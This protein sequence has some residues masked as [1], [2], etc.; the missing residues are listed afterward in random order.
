MLHS[1]P[2]RLSLPYTNCSALTAISLLLLGRFAK[3]GAKTKN[4]QYNCIYIRKDKFK[5]SGD[6]LPG[7]FLGKRYYVKN[8]NCFLYI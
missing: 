6:Y 2:L 1:P 5:L 4:Q 8:G 7:I 3:D